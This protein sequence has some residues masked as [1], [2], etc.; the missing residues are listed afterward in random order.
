VLALAVLAA[1]AN[2]AE[3]ADELEDVDDLIEAAETSPDLAATPERELAGGDVPVGGE[4]SAWD[5]AL[6]GGAERLEALARGKQ[7]S[8]WGRLEVSIAW[9]RSWDAPASSP[10]TRH[11]EV[12]L[13]ATWWR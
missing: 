4:L 7:P 2:A 10:A 9:Q 1:R 8:R 13:T 5:T 6:A 12:W 3:P 11:D